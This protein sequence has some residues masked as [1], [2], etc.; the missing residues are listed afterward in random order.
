WM[1]LKRTDTYD[2]EYRIMLDQLLDEMEPLSRPT[3][4]GMYEREAA[5]FVS[6]PNAI[7]PFHID[8]EVNFLLQIRG[9]KWIT[10]FDNTDRTVLSDEALENHFYGPGFHRNLEFRD[11]WQSRGTVY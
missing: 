9:C 11:E 5:I 2:P 10:V 8:H 3:E 6:S 4:P 1:V 7:T